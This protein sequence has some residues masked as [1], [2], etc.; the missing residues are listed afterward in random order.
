[1]KL[2][3]PELILDARTFLGEGP[4]WHPELG[5]LTSGGDGSIH[6]YGLDGKTSVYRKNAGTN[7]LLFDAKGRLIACEPEQRRVTRTELDGKITVLTPTLIDEGSGDLR[8]QVTVQYAFQTV[9][10]WPGGALRLI[11][12]CSGPWLFLR[13]IGI[14]GCC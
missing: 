1:M 11:S 2:S 4:A 3:T 10:T 12:M 13:F 6:R 9:I 7:G 14:G 5:V 8:V